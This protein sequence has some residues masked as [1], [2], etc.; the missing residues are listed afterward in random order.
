SSSTTA[1]EG[2][3][4]HTRFC[5]GYDR[6]GLELFVYGRCALDASI[7]HPTKF[8]ARQTFEAS[9]AIARLHGLSPQQTIYLQQNPVAIDG[10][11]FHND[12]IAVGN[13]DILFCHE[14]AYVDQPNAIDRLRKLYA[15][16]NSGHELRVIQVSTNE[17]SLT[18]AVDSYLF[19]SQL[20]VTDK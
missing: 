9:V 17:V 11:V 6:A 10:G 7:P 2:A 18:D 15:Q 13:L 8:P 16:L 19:N 4:N 3:A 1:D 14:L 20:V 5:S 12:V